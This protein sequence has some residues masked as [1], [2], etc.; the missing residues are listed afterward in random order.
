M[1]INDLPD[2]LTS[3]CK[4]FADDTSFFSKTINKK[5][6]EIEPNKDLKLISQ[7]AYQWKML[8]NPDPTKQATEV[9]FSHKHGNIPHKPLTFNNNKIQSAPAQKYLG[10]ILD[11]KLDFNQ[12][13]D[14]KINK[15]NKIIGTIRRLNDTF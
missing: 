6:S 1:Y 2:R 9:C 11:S 4:I 3:I 7:W 13:I 10:L 12:H 5:K 15:C 8:F 14:D